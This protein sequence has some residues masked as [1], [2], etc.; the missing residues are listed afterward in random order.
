[1]KLYISGYHGCHALS[2]P[3]WERELKRPLI[4]GFEFE[5]QSLPAWE[6]ELKPAQ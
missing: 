5:L 4:D 6:R 2:L 3:A 1:M